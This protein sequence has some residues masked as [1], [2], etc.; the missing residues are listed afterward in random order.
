MPRK[1]YQSVTLPEDLYLRLREEADRRGTTVP[2]LISDLISRPAEEKPKV[3][4]KPAAEGKYLH[5]WCRE[6]VRTGEDVERCPIRMR[7][8]PNPCPRELE[9][10]RG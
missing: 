10:Q 6:C 7:Y 1:G 2:K 5:F 3:V 4:Q 9:L 8:Y